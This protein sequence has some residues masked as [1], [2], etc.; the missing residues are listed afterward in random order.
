MNNDL[1]SRSLLLRHVQACKE[2][3]DALANQHCMIG[4]ADAL[5]GMEGMVCEMPTVD[6]VEVVRCKDCNVYNPCKFLDCTL[7]EIMVNADFFC[8]VGVRR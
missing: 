6:A 5:T 7:L 4:F 3:V 1:I 2:T 8:G